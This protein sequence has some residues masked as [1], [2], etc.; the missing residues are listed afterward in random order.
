MAALLPGMQY[1]LE[2]MES[3]IAQ[4]REQI[5]QAQEAQRS[6]VWDAAR[7]AVAAVLDTDAKVPKRLGR[8]PGSSNGKPGPKSVTS[9]RKKVMAEASRSYWDAMTPE[10]R[11]AEM[12]RRFKK[13]AKNAKAGKVSRKDTQKFNGWLGLTKAERKLRVEAMMAGRAAAKKQAVNGAAHH[14]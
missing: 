9:L 12:K 8:P 1:M 14:A 10:E 3:T 13:R 11:S 4:M 7:D 2:Q 5:R 6:G